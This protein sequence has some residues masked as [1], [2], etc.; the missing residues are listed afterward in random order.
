MSEV[1]SFLVFWLDPLEAMCSRKAK[2]QMGLGFY[3]YL[4]EMS[5]CASWWSQ[6]GL[7]HVEACTAFTVVFLYIL[8]ISY[9][10]CV[11]IKKK[12]LC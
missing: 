4:L 1:G 10:K 11:D 5:P 12:E 3:L 6:H 9:V 7:E 8:I 2:N